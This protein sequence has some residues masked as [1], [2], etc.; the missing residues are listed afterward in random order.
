MKDKDRLIEAIAQLEQIIT[1]YDPANHKDYFNYD[2]AYRKL[3]YK[4][5]EISRKQIKILQQKIMSIVNREKN[6]LREKDEETMILKKAGKQTLGLC[7]TTRG[8]K[9]V[10]DDG[11]RTNWVTIHEDFTWAADH[12]NI[13]EPIKN[14]L[15]KNGEKLLKLKNQINNSTN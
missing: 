13:N 4:K 9:F 15:H 10:I 14:F 8:K 11:W 7:Q 6:S 2:D 12:E 1:N 3:N 5:C